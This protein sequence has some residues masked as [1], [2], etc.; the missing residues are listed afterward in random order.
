M[1]AIVATH[2]I[3]GRKKKPW[4]WVHPSS[5]EYIFAY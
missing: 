3:G 1:V 2:K 5:V 4:L